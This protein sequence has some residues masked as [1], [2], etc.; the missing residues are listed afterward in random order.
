[1][2][3]K[4][5]TPISTS[6]PHDLSVW[7]V[8]GLTGLAIFV[9]PFSN[10]VF[11]PGAI[12]ALAGMGILIRHFR[13]IWAERWM[14]WMLV[15]MAALWLP[16]VL[17]LTGAINFER[18][19]RTA[20]TYPLYALSMVPLLWLARQRDVVT[21][22]LYLT[23]GLSVIWSLDGILEFFTG[24]NILGY[25]YNGRRV[26]GLF[27]PGLS[28]GIVL[29]HLL[30]FVLEA[31][32]RL[33]KKNSTAIFL[34]A[35]VAIVIVLSGSRA[36][37]L[38]MMISSVGYG[39]FLS[40]YYRPRLL[41]IAAAGAAVVLGLGATLWVSPDTRDRV[42]VVARI[43]EMN[44]EAVDA[45]T[46]KRGN[47]WLTA[48][49]VATDDPVLGVGVRGVEP[50]AHARGYTERE[51]A[52][53]HLYGLEVLVATGLIGLVS[54]LGAF[55]ALLFALIRVAQKHRPLSPLAATAALAV[56]AAANPI[57]AHWTPYGSY[58]A[59][60]GWIVIG[61]GLAALVQRGTDASPARA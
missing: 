59:S 36:A 13:A 3:D 30:P 23:L 2:A 31:S 54:Y 34:P 42:T 35:L 50:A 47:L 17:A 52:H 45:A 19:L 40:W 20:S 57:N 51:F 39:I 8:M 15:L 6:T 11:A 9:L 27:Y 38:M 10:S 18:A 58:A 16:Q 60:V 29:A 44:V 1:M 41:T 32:R 14:R 26:A 21:P 46:S 33:A 43:A 61:M 37:I 7:A 5:S 56:I 4:P 25:P 24:S 28:L 53:V 12:L 22:L 48:W 55:S 49:Q